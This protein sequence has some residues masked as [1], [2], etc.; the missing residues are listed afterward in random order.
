M[1]LNAD[2]GD[3]AVRERAPCECL[4]DRVGCRLRL[5]TIRSSDKITEFGVTFAVQD[6]FHVLEEIFPRRF[7]GAAG[8]YQLVEARDGQGLPRYTIL[9]NPR[10]PVVDEGRLPA[11]F[12]AEMGKLQHYYGFMTSAWAREQ[13]ITVRR[14]PPYATGAGK[15]L[16]FHRAGDSPVAGGTRR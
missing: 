7:G 1:L 3:R 2:I 6:V 11:A 5:H 9:V 15:V 13:L 4:Y 14:A 10:L 8:D 16:P 12:L